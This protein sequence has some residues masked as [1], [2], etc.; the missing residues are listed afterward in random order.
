MRPILQVIITTT[1]SLLFTLINGLRF[2]WSADTI[3][4]WLCYQTLFP[5]PQRKNRKKQS[6]N[7]RLVLLYIAT[8]YFFL[9]MSFPKLNIHAILCL[10]NM[11]HYHRCIY[12]FSRDVNF[13]IT[14][15]LTLACISDP[16][17]YNNTTMI[18]T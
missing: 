17:T 6:G 7:V 4:Y 11:Q 2:S 15:F 8:Y 10:V 14:K 16:Y 13:M 1:S 9:D 3:R 18:H 12:K 5:F